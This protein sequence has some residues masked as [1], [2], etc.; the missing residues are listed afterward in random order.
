MISQVWY[1]VPEN[2][3]F[4]GFTSRNGGS[5]VGSNNSLRVIVSD[6]YVHRLNS[7][8][9]KAVVKDMADHSDVIALVGSGCNPQCPPSHVYLWHSRLRKKQEITC[10]STILSIALRLETL[11]VTLAHKTIV[12]DLRDNTNSPREFTTYSNPKGLLWCSSRNSYPIIATLGECVGS[13]M[14]INCNDSSKSNVQVFG[15][16]LSAFTLTV[17]SVLLAASSSNGTKIRVVNTAT[18]ECMHELHRGRS[19]AEVYS[20]AFQ[21]SKNFLGCSSSKNT[22]HIFSIAQR[23]AGS[24]LKIRDVNE[25]SLCIFDEEL[26]RVHVVMKKSSRRYDFSLQEDGSCALNSRGYDSD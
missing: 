11:I 2:L 10:E 21:C 15:E 8:D 1:P 25:K 20:L 24:I 18:G 12:Y 4:V 9:L 17:D 14:L 22:I 26:S 7:L 19:I 13:V 16:D 23:H 6:P 5:S 3:I